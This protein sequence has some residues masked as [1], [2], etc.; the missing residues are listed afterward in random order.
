[1]G[2]RAT[3]LPIVEL[4]AA[5]TIYCDSVWF[6]V[7]ADIIHCHVLAKR[8]CEDGSDELHRQAVIVLTPAA[9]AEA[10]EEASRAAWGQI[11]VTKEK[12]ASGH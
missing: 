3:R 8:I 10:L 6:E 2:T 11:P 4:I 5:P 7:R 12:R 1:M 9:F